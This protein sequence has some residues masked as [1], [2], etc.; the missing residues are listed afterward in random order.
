MIRIFAAILVLFTLGGIA[1]SCYG[2]GDQPKPSG[3][4]GY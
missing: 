1:G 4:P 3:A 2:S